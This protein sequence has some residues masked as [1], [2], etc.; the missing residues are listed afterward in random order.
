MIDPVAYLTYLYRTLNIPLHLISTDGLQTALS[1]PKNTTF[2]P[3]G[4]Y[5]SE[6]LTQKRAV[7]FVVT[8]EFLDFGI[9]SLKNNAQKIIIGPISNTPCSDESIR[10][11]AH[12]LSIPRN[13]LA[14]F[15]DYF[16]RLKIYSFNQFVDILCLINYSLNQTNIK[17]SSL[18]TVVDDHEKDLALKQLQ[19]EAAYN[20]KENQDL[21]NTY[22]FEKRYL[23]Y[24][25]AGAVE[26]LRNF[27][28]AAADL[29]IGYVAE[30]NIRQEKNLFISSITLATR[31][32]IE[33]GLNTETA[34]QLSDTAI[35]EMERLSSRE[36]ISRLELNTILQFAERVRAQKIPHVVSRMVKQALNYITTHTDEPLTIDYLAQKLGYSHSY[37]S[38][39]FKK[40]VGIPLHQYIQKQRLQEAQDLLLFTDKS[41]NEI[42]TFLNFSTQSY[43]QNVFK[44]EF[45]ITPYHF[46]QQGKTEPH[47]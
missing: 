27:I 17:P 37:L 8:K 29:R 35:M 21:H 38:L 18:I 7:D 39:T 31:A 28:F 20:S 3:F 32:A 6:L 43:F 47:A 30:N 26:K 5:K 41:I 24:V 33:G 19:T 46:R 23:N 42:S 25:K 4:R 40:E 36:S 10:R 1:L 22:E 14:A 2:D 13:Y 44:K 11:I 45:E 9:I 12:D 34:Y 16:K 15:N